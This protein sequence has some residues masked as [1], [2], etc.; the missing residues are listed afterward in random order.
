MFHGAL[1]LCTLCISPYCFRDIIEDTSPSC[2]TE[3]YTARDSWQGYGM[4]WP[5]PSTCR[6]T[7]MWV[8]THIKKN[9]G[10]SIWICNISDHVC[11]AAVTTAGPPKGQRWVPG[12]RSMSATK[13]GKVKKLCMG[14]KVAVEKAMQPRL[15]APTLVNP[16]PRTD[17]WQE[18]GKILQQTQTAVWCLL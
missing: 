13:W 9:E 3:L 11:P 15:T 18:C 6:R 4:F 17:P 12:E 5:P 7:V 14:Q 16:P 2:L 1:R 8:N 10:K